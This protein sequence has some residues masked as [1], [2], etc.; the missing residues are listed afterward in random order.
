MVEARTLSIC[1]NVAVVYRTVNYPRDYDA[2]EYHDYFV[3]D[4]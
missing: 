2:L 4:T 3:T 1:N